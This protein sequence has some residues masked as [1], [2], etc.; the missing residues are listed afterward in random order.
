MTDTQPVPCVLCG[1]DTTHR[2]HMEPRGRA[3][4]KRDDPANLCPCC[5][6]CHD[7]LEP[8]GTWRVRRLGGHWLVTDVRTGEEISRRP[9]EARGTEALTIITQVSDILDP[10]KEKDRLLALIAYL[11]DYDLQLLDEKMMRVGQ[12]SARVRA[13]LQYEAWRRYPWK[14]APNWAD[15]IALAFGVAPQTVRENVRTARIFAEDDGPAMDWSY[16]ILAAHQPEPQA[17]LE[18]VRESW[19]SGG[20]VRQAKVALGVAEPSPQVEDW[21]VCPTCQ[22]RGRVRRAR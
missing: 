17:A 18:T 2:H 4:E 20:T 19:Q 8:E 9:A 5:D 15:K 22:G 6:P 10:R 12:S 14:L 13:I 16:Y 21:D 7:W 1:Q 11:S 3:P